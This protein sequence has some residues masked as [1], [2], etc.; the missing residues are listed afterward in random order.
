M[1]PEEDYELQPLL[2]H[3]DMSTQIP[4]LVDTRGYASPKVR[5]PGR[6]NDDVSFKDEESDGKTSEER[7]RDGQPADSDA[8][9]LTQ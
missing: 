8:V 2:A 4:E 9:S 1:E 6:D 3:D 5:E 7:L